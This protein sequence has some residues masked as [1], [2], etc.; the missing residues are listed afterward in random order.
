[1]GATLHSMKGALSAAR[2]GATT[3]PMTRG[4]HVAVAGF[5][6]GSAMGA[7]AQGEVPAARFVNTPARPLTEDDYR[8]SVAVPRG[9]SDL[10]A[11]LPR[12]RL[13]VRDPRDLA[14][15]RSALVQLTA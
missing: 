14:A 2:A 7:W 5:V 6:L 13:D 1:M 3:R 15:L 10:D 8:V 11:A 12:R 9:L 4:R